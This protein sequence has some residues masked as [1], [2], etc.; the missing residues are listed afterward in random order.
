MERAKKRTVG[1]PFEKSTEQGPQVDEEQM[2]KILNLIQRGVKDGAKLLVGGSR[3]GER[4][5]FVQ[6]TVFAHVED[7]HHIAQEEVLH[8][9]LI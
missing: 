4:G 9:F 6:P 3:H 8:Q 2:E 7:H 5:F 1:N